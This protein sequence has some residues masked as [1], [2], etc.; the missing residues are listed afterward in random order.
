MSVKRAILD[1][2]PK[3]VKSIQVQITDMESCLR[4]QFLSPGIS[5]LRGYWKTGSTVAVFEVDVS[6]TGNIIL[7]VVEPEI[8]GITSDY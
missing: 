3:P 1:R 4:V 6:L 8:V 7:C 5:K 2:H